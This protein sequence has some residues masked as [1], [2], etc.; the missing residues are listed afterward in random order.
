MTR[1][2][3][4][5]GI[6]L[7][8][9]VLVHPVMAAHRTFVSAA[10]GNDANPCTRPLPC[11]NFAAAV[12]QTDPE[13][14]VIALDSGGYGTVTITHS[15]SLIAPAGVHAGITGFASSPFT[16][17]AVTIDALEGSHVVLRNLALNNYS[18]YYGIRTR[19]A[20]VLYVEN[21]VVN[22]FI[23]GIDF[24]PD[25][26][27]G[28]LYV[29]DTTVRSLGGAGRT[30][31]SGIVVAGGTGIRAILDS[32]RVHQNPSGIRVI[33]A[34]A[35]IRKSIVS[36]GGNHGF[37]AET[38]SKVIIENSVSSNSANGF[39]A[40]DGSI[41]TMTRCVAVSNFTGIYARG[42]TIF[43]TGST[44][45]ANDTGVLTSSGGIVRSRRTNTLQANTTAGTFLTFDP[46]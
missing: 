35:T 31:G 43:V 42:G 28:H 8:T 9:F 29:S 25:N 26:S 1:K 17:E 41:M 7:S 22:N 23:F 32:V 46:N 19:S 6:A 30:I 12:L 18:A 14:K 27:N 21:C 11:R 34:E 13:G 45:T 39:E 2:Q 20:G 40:S 15:L 3:L 5:H 4:L 10:T 16:G 36:D 33:N 24:R 44:I 37:S 38:G